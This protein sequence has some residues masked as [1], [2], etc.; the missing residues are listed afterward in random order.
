MKVTERIFGKMP[1]GRE[2]K[3]F[4]LETSA[5]L[6]MSITNYG[7]IITSIRMPDRNG[8]VEEISAGFPQ[9][10]SY[11]GE[12]PYFGAIVGRFANRIG[13][14]SFVIDG[15]KYE[16]GKNQDPNHLHGGF[17]G[18]DK[19]LW[20]C[21]VEASESDAKL[22]FRYKSPDLEEG[23]PGNLLCEV[24]YSLLDNNFLW[25][26]FSAETDAPTHVNLTH[27]GYYNLGGFKNKITD[28]LLQLK[29]SSY[30]ELDES[31][32]PTGRLLDCKENDMDYN[33]LRKVKVPLDNCFVM[34][35]DPDYLQPKVRLVHEPSGRS[36]S[37]RSTQP[38]V[39]V[40]TGNF[41]DGT[42]KGHNDVSYM[43]HSAICLETQDF[44]DSPNKPG[45]PST[46]LRPGER[47][48][49][50]VFYQFDVVK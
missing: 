17:E 42:L 44:P 13:G 43:Q 50:M 5:G 33:D 11:L 1:D 16:L 8:K 32:I 2:V 15:K 38:G 48:E 4:E 40:Y 24:M 47:Y 35:E 14:A 45:F 22:I 49:H 21:K 19:K 9:L 23:Y 30:L 12:H 18:L 34:D 29:S 7:C 46:L 39:Q 6:G 20:D 25:M 10:E 31:F 41:L 27:H 37:I 28:H 3:I 26:S 36:L